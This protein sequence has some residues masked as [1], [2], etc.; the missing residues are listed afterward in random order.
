MHIGVH[1]LGV[2]A[3][4][5]ALPGKGPVAGVL[6][7]GHALVRPFPA[8]DG[9]QDIAAHHGNCA[10]PLVI[11]VALPQGLIGGAVV[12]ELHGGKRAVAGKVHGAVGIH[13]HCVKLK[14]VFVG[15][16]RE[17]AGIDCAAAVRPEE[18]V[19]RHAVFVIGK[20]HKAIN[21][22]VCGVGVGLPVG[23]Q[24]IQILHTVGRGAVADIPD[25]Q[26]GIVRDR[27]PVRQLDVPGVVIGCKADLH[28][29]GG[30][31]Q[32]DVQLIVAAHV[33][34]AREG[35]IPLGVLIPEGADR[36]A[37]LQRNHLQR[38][39]FGLTAGKAEEGVGLVGRHR[40]A[41]QISAGQLQA[42]ALGGQDIRAVLRPDHIQL[43]RPAGLVGKNPVGRTPAVLGEVHHNDFVR[44]R[45]VVIVRRQAGSGIH[46][47][48]VAADIAH[49]PV[50]VLFVIRIVGNH[51]PIT[52]FG[53]LERK[54]LRVVHTEMILAP[55]GFGAVDGNR[56]VGILNQG[57]RPQPVIGRVRACPHAGCLGGAVLIGLQGGAVRRQCHGVHA[58]GAAGDKNHTVAADLHIVYLGNCIGVGPIRPPAAGHRH[59]TK[60][61]AL[62]GVFINPEG[63]I[64]RQAQI[65]ADRKAIK[66][67][68]V[69]YACG[70]AFAVKIIGGEHIEISLPV[71]HAV[72]DR[73]A[74][75]LA[76][77]GLRQ[78]RRNAVLL[79]L[80]GGSI[81]LH[82]GNLH[83]VRGAVQADKQ[84]SA[85]LYFQRA[86]IGVFALVVAVL[87]EAD[88]IAVP[89]INHFHGALVL[90]AAHKAAEGIA[91]PGIH[92][93]A[94]H[95][96]LRRQQRALPAGENL[97]VVLRPDQPAGRG[98]N[99][100]LGIDCL[101][102]GV[103]GGIHGFGRDRKNRQRGEKKD[104]RQKH[105]YNLFGCFHRDSPF[106]F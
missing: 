3:D 72:S 50:A 46:H 29:L 34:R 94:G 39:V 2:I 76:R 43:L 96:P 30:S 58:D 104:R 100:P 35:I 40:K 33:H 26:L 36:P 99:D 12:L 66:P 93:K 91:L 92:G 13:I 23:N 51:F 41:L 18:D 45:A 21:H 73:P 79:H 48:Q 81:V 89:H 42:L 25:H 88:R 77:F 32:P 95:L 5:A 1:P 54:G 14:D 52:G 16:R 62:F 49:G 53:G 15:P 56:Q 11:A 86:G 7:P 59:H 61:N 47:I 22:I 90:P 82:N 74:E 75:Q 4:A 85:L 44:G 38:A 102:V 6:H 69:G 19:R 55:V 27:V 60:A 31:V 78:H 80:P 105:G 98:V 57:N 37:G 83:T 84:G 97:R 67:V 20:Q 9:C 70:V 64:R 103:T 87:P 63:Q 106:E 24:H 28:P 68:I 101:A 65:L 10:L 8:V 17:R 71:Y